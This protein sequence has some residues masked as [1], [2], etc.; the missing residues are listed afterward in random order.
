ME[1][2]YFSLCWRLDEMIL[3]LVGTTLGG[4]V[5]LLPFHHADRMDK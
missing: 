4:R 3:L 1:S 5:F 2:A